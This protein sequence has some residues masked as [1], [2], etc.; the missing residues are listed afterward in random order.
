[1]LGLAAPVALA[2]LA[3]AAL[4]ATTVQ[5]AFP[6]APTHGTVN[7]NFLGLSVELSF[8]NIYCAPLPSP[9]PLHPG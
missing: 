4:G 3:T 5:V 7:S 6:P 2:A 8:F 1:M 9:L